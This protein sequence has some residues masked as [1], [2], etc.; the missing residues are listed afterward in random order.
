M[1]AQDPR[2]RD[3]LVTF[4]VPQRVDELHAG[5]RLE[6]A[7]I[8]DH[9]PA[10]LTYEGP[11]SGD[12]GTVR[13]LARGTVVR[14]DEHLQI[15]RETKTNYELCLSWY[16]RA[17]ELH[18][19]AKQRQQE[20]Q[21]QR[22]EGTLEERIKISDACLSDCEVVAS[23]LNAAPPE[24]PKSWVAKDL[25]DG[26]A[27]RDGQQ[28]LGAGFVP[29]SLRTQPWNVCPFGFGIRPCADE[30]LAR[31]T[32]KRRNSDGRAIGGRQHRQL[33]VQDHAARRAGRGRGKRP[34]KTA[35]RESLPAV[36]PQGEVGQDV[37]ARPRA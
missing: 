30:A 5:Q 18:Q 26:A 4:R 13:R 8:A 11:V 9:R 12:R 17:R 23:Y 2:G 6:A 37:S 15:A 28:I 21:A 10:Y 16:R 14:L 32:G 25:I 34:L 31:V 24:E 35:E 33:T 22:E 7:R 36:V 19:T 3:P 1:I 20:M 29:G 27:R